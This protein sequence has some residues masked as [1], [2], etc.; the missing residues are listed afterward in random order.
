MGSGFR[1]C[2]KPLLLVHRFVFEMLQFLSH[3]TNETEYNITGGH[4]TLPHYL[5]KVRSSNLW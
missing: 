1:F 3:L 4:Y 2:R 5:A